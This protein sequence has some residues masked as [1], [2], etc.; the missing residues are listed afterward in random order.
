MF[1]TLDYLLFQY[2]Q[3]ITTDSFDAVSFCASE[4]NVLK[5]KFTTGDI[6]WQFLDIYPNY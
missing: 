5:L 3:T 1:N 6:S 2:L 4:P